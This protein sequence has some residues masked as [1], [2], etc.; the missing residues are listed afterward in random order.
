M[1]QPEITA[2]EDGPSIVATCQQTRFHIADDPR[3]SEVSVQQLTVS[4]LPPSASAV[5]GKAKAKAVAKALD[6][7]TDVDLK[8]KP[9]VHYGLLGRNGSGKSTLLRALATKIIPGIPYSTRIALL[10][11]TAAN[12]GTESALPADKDAFKK[13]A[14]RFILESDTARNEL[15]AD[16]DDLSRGQDDDGD[17][18]WAQLRAFRQLQYNRMQRRLGEL[19]K[20]SALRSGARGSQARKDQ[21]TFE[22]Q[23]EEAKDRIDSVEPPLDSEECQSELLQASQLMVSIQAEL[24][25]RRLVDVETR[26][27]DMLRCLGFNES[28]LKTPLGQLSEGWQ[29]RCMLANALLQDADILIL[30]EP[31]NFLDLLG[32]IWLQKYL[33]DLQSTSPKTVVVVSHD[34]DF[35]DHVCEEIIILK[36]KA[37]VY[38][39]GNLTAYE[40]DMKS[41]RTNL[42]RAKDAQ[43]RQTAHMEKTIASNIKAGKKSGDE[44]RLRQAASRKKRI[45]DRSGMQLNAKGVRFKK[46]RDLPGFH[47]SSREEIEIPPEEKSV[48]L[49]L[50]LAPD[51][52]FPGPLVSLEKVSFAYGP[53][54]DRVL[55]EIDLSIHMGSRVGVV[56]LNGSG[57]ST[58]IKLLVED[59][60]PTKGSVTRHPRLK[61]GYYSQAAVEDLRVAGT[62]TPSRTALNT[63]MDDAG[64]AMDEGEVRG[65]LGSFGLAGR[66]ASDVP[67]AKLSGG[68][69]VRLALARIVWDHPH[70]LVLDE[71]TTHLDFYSVIALAKALRAFNGAL[72]LVSHDRFLIKAVIERDTELLDLEE[73]EMSSDAEEDAELQRALYQLKKGSLNRLQHGIQNFEGSLEKRVAKMTL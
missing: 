71:I 27:L 37:L 23:V 42:T 57:K 28:R 38:F 5:S 70:L 67:I 4:V 6:I 60:K 45:E 2:R 50:P 29:M 24:D 43:D 68:Q 51:L 40:D 39:D 20:N 32:I 35:I 26:A 44:N 31:T 21:L 8:L 17:E 33:V 53:K 63:M 14:I 59:L 36:D 12:D 55:H 41:R 54:R 34:R 61:L 25:E 73:D 62:A 64:D 11:Q 49:V 65:L 13:S 7:V 9:G 46:S 58:L 18:G 30:D 72:M 22:K 1:A 10:Q 3:G 48:T 19:Q 69:L 66:V 47:Y 15:Q 56:G 16:L 52:R